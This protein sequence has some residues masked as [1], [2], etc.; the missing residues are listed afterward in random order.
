MTSKEALGKIKKLIFIMGE[1]LVAESKQDIS[2]EE[3]IQ[4]IRKTCNKYGVNG[5]DYETI[6]QDLDRL[7]EH[8]KIEEEIGVDFIT[9][10]KMLKD[11]VYINDGGIVDEIGH[12]YKDQVKSIEHWPVWGFT[13]GDNVEYAFKDRGRTWVL[14]KEEF[15]K[16]IK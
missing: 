6:K 11:D 13:V 10:V 2:S 5:T 3:A 16:N 8:R 1:I 7:E 12:I 4:R 14:D 15:Y 9:L